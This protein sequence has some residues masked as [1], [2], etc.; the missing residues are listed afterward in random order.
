MNRCQIE[1]YTLTNASPYHTTCL[2]L[3][4][5]ASTPDPRVLFNQDLTV[6]AVGDNVYGPITA[7]TAMNAVTLPAPAP[8]LVDI[9]NEQLRPMN[10][11]SSLVPQ[12]SA[13]SRYVVYT[14]NGNLHTNRAPRLEVYH[15]KNIDSVAS[16]I[17]IPGEVRLNSVSYARSVMHPSLPMLGFISWIVPPSDASVRIS[18]NCHILELDNPSKWMH[19]AQIA[20]ELKGK[21]P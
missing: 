2:E 12:F 7:S 15:L 14:D 16:R 18:L 10:S 11:R 8:K 5:F 3:P 20:T 21:L 9:A 13:C 19:V 6:L 4:L 1:F 17:N